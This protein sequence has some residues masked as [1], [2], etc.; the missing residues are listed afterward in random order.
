[1]LADGVAHEAL[2]R[3]APYDLVF[4]NILARPLCALAPRIAQ[5]T[6]TGADI[7]LSGLLARDVP[8][9]LSAYRRQGMVLGKRLD[10][11]GWATLLMQKR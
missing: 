3:G 10:L 8:G 5:L 11:E 9:V 1:V 7:I 4:A 6:D 2:R